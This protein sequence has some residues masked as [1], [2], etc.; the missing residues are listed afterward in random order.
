MPETAEKQ[1]RVWAM[2]CHL[3]AL[4]G[5]I[6]IPLGHIIGPLIVWLIKRED[7]PYIDQQGKE[8]L[9]FQISMT[10]YGIVAGILMVV[11]IGFVLLAGLVVLNLVLIIVAS[12]KVNQG[13]DF[14]Y[15]LTIR[16][17]K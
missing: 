3:L 11:L 7:H 2:A 9:N 14:R 4:S 8:A 13:E 10:I 6:G 17:L 15:P 12:V 5:Y 1:A 16:F